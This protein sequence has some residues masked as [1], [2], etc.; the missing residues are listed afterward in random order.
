MPQLKQIKNEGSSM[1]PFAENI[2]KERFSCIYMC[3]IFQGK[4]A[5]CFH[6][7]RITGCEGTGGRL[8]AEALFHAS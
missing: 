2:S 7:R 3:R 6:P 4:L 5:H 1:S 8:F